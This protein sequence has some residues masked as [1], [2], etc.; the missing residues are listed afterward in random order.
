MVNK[1]DK[2]VRVEKTRGRV[3]LGRVVPH[4]KYGDWFRVS[5]HGDQIV[6]TPVRAVAKETATGEGYDSP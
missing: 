5:M 1:P 3:S 6:L 2:L 4:L